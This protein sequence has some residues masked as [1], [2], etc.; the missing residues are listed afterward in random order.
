MNVRK[1]QRH[2]RAFIAC[3]NARIAALMRLWDR[4]EMRYVRKRLKEKK[5]SRALD[6]TSSFSALDIDSKTRTE[7]EKQASKWDHID[8]KMEE[9]IGKHRLMVKR[10][11]V[12]IGACTNLVSWN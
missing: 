10:I 8:A 4:L 5:E 11:C 9:S 6:K 1:S 7:I 12:I 2:G 3:K